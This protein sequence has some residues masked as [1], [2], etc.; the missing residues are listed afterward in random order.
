MITS[1]KLGLTVSAITDL[2]YCTYM[3]GIDNTKF[4]R[5]EITCTCMGS[6]RQEVTTFYS[7]NVWESTE[8]NQ[9]LKLN[10][11]AANVRSNIDQ[12]L[13]VVPQAH[14]DPPFP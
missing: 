1:N 6:L 9:P 13:L 7:D 10:V 3:Y 4:Y 12:P 11:N 8:N 5:N 14:F 2:G